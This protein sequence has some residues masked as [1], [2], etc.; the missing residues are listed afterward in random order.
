[1]YHENTVQLSELKTS[2]PEKTFIVP[3]RQK[4][5]IMLHSVAQIVSWI[6]HNTRFI[7]R[8]DTIWRLQIMHW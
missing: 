8:T 4:N 2:F 5:F 3:E 1:M 7:K 6:C